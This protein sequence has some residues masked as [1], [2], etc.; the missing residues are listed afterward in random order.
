[1]F[2]QPAVSDLLAF[3]SSVS[4]FSLFASPKLC[5]LCLCQGGRRQFVAVGRRDRRG[6]DAHFGR[7]NDQRRRLHGTWFVQILWFLVCFLLR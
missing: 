4:A 2:H 1:M 6:P 5:Q 7:V 3:A